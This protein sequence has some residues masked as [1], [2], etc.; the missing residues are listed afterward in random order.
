[1]ILTR[2]EYSYDRESRQMMFT[3]EK[4]EKVHGT[5]KKEDEKSF[6]HRYPEN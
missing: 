6:Y 4:E 1:M 3:G 2:E 5:E